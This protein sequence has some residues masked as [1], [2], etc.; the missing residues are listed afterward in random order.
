M[1]RLDRQRHFGVARV[2]HHF[3]DGVLDLRA[4]RRDILRGHTS[5]PRIL[6]QA[7]DHENDAGRAER[8]G[9]IDGPTVIVA[10]LP[11]MGGIRCEH[12]AAA[13]A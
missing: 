2:N 6:R 12:P 9:L 1:Q 5:R 8:L 11:A 3:G 4:R 13:I 7:P 10:R